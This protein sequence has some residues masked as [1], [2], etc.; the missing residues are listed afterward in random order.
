MTGGSRSGMSDILLLRSP[1]FIYVCTFDTLAPP[2]FDHMLFSVKQDSSKG[3]TRENTHIVLLAINLGKNDCDNETVRAYIR[4][5][6]S[7]YDQELIGLTAMG[8]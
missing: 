7:S 4:A 1:C 5:I 8:M 6:R 3:H 2:D